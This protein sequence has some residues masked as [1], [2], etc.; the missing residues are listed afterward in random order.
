MQTSLSQLPALPAQYAYTLP[1]RSVTTVSPARRAHPAQG[2]T[3]VLYHLALSGTV[4]MC[5]YLSNSYM[6]SDQPGR[7]CETKHS[8]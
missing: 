3:A 2:A 6:L 1:I 4:Y 7:I 5:I 8:V